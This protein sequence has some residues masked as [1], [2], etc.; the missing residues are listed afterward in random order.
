MTNPVDTQEVEVSARISEK[1]L[2]FQK[3][4]A[5]YERVLAEK[6]QRIA[7]IEAQLKAK[8]VSNDDED[9]DQDPYID[10][11]KLAKT[12]NRFGE[13][14]QKQTQGE[15]QKAVQE[16]LSNER[17][18]NWLRQNP[19]FESILS[20]A[21]KLAQSDPELAETIL[22]MPDNFE[23]HKLVYRT[24]KTMGLDKPRSKENSVQDKINQNRMNPGYQ[25]NTA[26][27]PPYASQSDFSESGKKAAYDKLMQ[28]KSTMRLG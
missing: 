8:Q 14:S 26:A 21:D 11:R 13:Q 12:L 28:L 24:I 16:A 6:E 7:D 5:S 4:K 20:H 3:Q 10:K 22:K 17:R 27:S 19:D 18:D 25:Q 1:E 9:D 2:N 15:I 23:R